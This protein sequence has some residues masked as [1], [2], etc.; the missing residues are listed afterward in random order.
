MTDEPT[1]FDFLEV[2]AS[3]KELAHGAVNDVAAI[4]LFAELML[5]A[6][7][8]PVNALDADRL[9]RDLNQLLDAAGH[10]SALLAQLMARCEVGRQSG[11]AA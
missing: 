4:H 6:V 8:D 5:E 11:P 9:K 3:I 7:S 10:A 2:T 1:Q